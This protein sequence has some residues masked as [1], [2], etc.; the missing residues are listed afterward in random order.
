MVLCYAVQMN[1]KLKS[2][3]LVVGDLPA[4]IN[5]SKGMAID[6][7][8]LGL[9]V[10][11]DRLCLVQVGDGNGNVWLVKFNGA[12]DYAKANNLRAYL[13]D[14][15]IQKIYHFARFDLSVIEHYLGVGQ[16]NVY[17]TKTASRLCRT[18]SDKHGLKSLCV[19]LLGIE[20]DKEQQTSDWGAPMLSEAQ[21]HYA[22][23]DVLYLHALRDELEKKLESVHR[24]HLAH[25]IHKKRES[26]W[27]NYREEHSSSVRAESS[28]CLHQLNGNPLCVIGKKTH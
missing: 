11:R 1:I 9:N 13:G 22:A 26:G 8:T 25:G 6:T 28:R 5:F 23:S 4:G 14:P 19:E 27:N 7:E 18:Y 12:E 2:L 10:H 16:Q 3:D 17:C 21:K 20:L 15:A 24:Q